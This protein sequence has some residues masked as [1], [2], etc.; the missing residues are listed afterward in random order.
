MIPMATSSV[1]TKRS[2]YRFGIAALLV[3]LGGGG[4]GLARVGQETPTPAAGTSSTAPWPGQGAVLAAAGPG[5]SRAAAVEQVLADSDGLGVAS[6]TFTTSSANPLVSTAPG[7]QVLVAPDRAAGGPTARSPWQS[8]QAELAAGAVAELIHTDQSRASEV[9]S[10]VSVSPSGPADAGARSS[11]GPAPLG[12][13][14]ASQTDG[15]TDADRVEQA[16]GVL[17]RFGLTPVVVRILHP[18]GAAIVVRAIAPAEVGWTLDRLVT[19]LD[20][21]AVYEGVFV[22]LDD[23]AGA[24]LVEQQSDYRIASH[25]T[26]AADG[27]GERFGVAADAGPRWSPLVTAG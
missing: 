27:Q 9:L 7:L 26:W 15:R 1:R 11:I 2:A 10:D 16:D 21:D 13:V 18:L 5:D 24:A 22:E 8:F 4:Y 25:S 20:G 6:M 3:G 19:A 12:Q 23:P 17:A 14:F